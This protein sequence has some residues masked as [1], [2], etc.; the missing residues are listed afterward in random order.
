MRLPR[1]VSANPQYTEFPLTQKKKKRKEK[2]Y[3]IECQWVQC[4][5]VCVDRGQHSGA[6]VHVPLWAFVLM[7]F[8][9]QIKAQ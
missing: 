4:V 2:Q 5:C 6:S 1:D 8:L 3:F 9:F 7:Q